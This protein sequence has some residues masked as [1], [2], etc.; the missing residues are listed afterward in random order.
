MT[1]SLPAK[2]T[3]GDQ[4]VTPATTPN[5]GSDAAR[6]QGCWCAVMDNHRGDP[7]VGRIRGFWITQGCPL[8][9]PQGG[10]DV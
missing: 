9:D 7:E 3:E 8:H 10:T 2:H 5:P 6:A 1:P 4:S